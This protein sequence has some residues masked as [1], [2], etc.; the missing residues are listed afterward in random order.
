MTVRIAADRLLD[1][2]RSLITGRRVGLLVNPTSVTSRLEHLVLALHGADDVRVTTLFGPEHGVWGTE[3]DMA[4]VASGVDRLTGLPVHSLYGHTEASLRPSPEMLT[5]IDVLVY[6]VQDVGSRYYTFVYTMM[7]AM[8]ACADAG[9]DFVVLDRP[10]PIGGVAVE[11]N[12]VHEGFTS[13]VGLH[14][15]ATRH[16]MTAGELAHLF[17][18]ERGIDVELEVVPMQGW[19]REQLWDD[20][21]VPWV[22]PS[23]NM[24]RP[25]TALV[26]PG[27]CLLEGTNLS[28]GRG[29]TLPFEVFGAPWIEPLRLAEALTAEGLPGCVARPLWFRPTFQKHAGTLCGGVQLHVTDAAAFAPV[30][31]GLA[32]LVHAR[33]L[34]P[35]LFAWRR[36]A[37]EFVEDRPAIDLLLGTSRLRALIDE[38]AAVADLVA[39]MEPDRQ[40]FL[41]RRAPY[42]LYPNGA[43]A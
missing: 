20:T 25:S 23:P 18:A 5:D 34:W 10:N 2:R 6:D 33:R 1:E 21:G 35:D 42:L 28:E 22:N 36:E 15:L 11:G 19:R 12:V 4:Q 32:V 3:Q 7:L 38:G 9:V 30:R 41:A 13:F 39:D 26:Y 8:E 40:A 29:T 31:A 16:G 27:L 37:Y 24:P 17:R 14:P 43:A